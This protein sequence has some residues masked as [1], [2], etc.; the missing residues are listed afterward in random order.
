MLQV[1]NSFT[2]QFVGSALRTVKNFRMMLTRKDNLNW[3]AADRRNRIVGYVCC[4]L[5]KPTNRGEFREIIVDP[6]HS[7]EQAARPLVKKIIEVLQRRKVA[8]IAAGSVRN[9]ALEK[10]FP[11]MGFFESES[12][13]VFMYAILNVQKFLNELSTVFTNRLKQLENWNGLTQ[14]ECEGH[15]LFLEKKSK[16]V[17]EIVWTNKPADFKISV[18]KEILTKL[19]FGSADPL[20]SHRTGL[21][22]VEHTEHRGKTSHLLKALF[23]NIQFLIM[24]YW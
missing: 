7:F 13:D 3:V 12:N 22:K 19:I 16:S 17:Q 1:Y 15:S 6:K 21:L 24:D 10:L 9:P 14:I 23:P 5:D 4:R 11:K 8:A 20:E 18:T 2:K